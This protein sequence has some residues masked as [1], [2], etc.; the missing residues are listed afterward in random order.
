MISIIIKK[1]KVYN[2]NTH[3]QYEYTYIDRY[4]PKV[5]LNESE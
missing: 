1:T 4:G 3:T 2:A 5:I